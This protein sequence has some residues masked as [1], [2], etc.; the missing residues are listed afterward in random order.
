[1][2]KLLLS[3]LIGASFAS[4][5]IAEPV[6]G[7]VQD[8]YVNKTVQI[9]REVTGCNVVDVPIYDNKE[10]S[11]GQAITGAIIG[12]VIGNQFGSGS[13]KDAMT[14]LG[15]IVGANV[16]EGRQQIVGYRKEERCTK[17]VY[18]EDKKVRVYSHSVVKFVHE[19]QS[20]TL[21]FKK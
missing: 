8:V 20:Y 3:T 13:G 11:A 14:V 7:S 18:Y 12:G 2:K 15:A 9:P 19:G 16:P 4:A 5:A 21:E 10:A 1:M 6:N 17:D